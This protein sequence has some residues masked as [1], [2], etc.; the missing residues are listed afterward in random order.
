MTAYMA[1]TNSAAAASVP[2]VVTTS[3]TK[4]TAPSTRRC[5]DIRGA[6]RRSLDL[7]AWRGA[8]GPIRRTRS[9]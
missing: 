9:M 2:P 7:P 3:S 6:G 8:I 4:T 5:E 1:G